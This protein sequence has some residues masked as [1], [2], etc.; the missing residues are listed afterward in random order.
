MGVQA[1]GGG[2]TVLYPAKL[3]Q[4]FMLCRGPT[5]AS[6]LFC[7][8]NSSSFPEWGFQYKPQIAPLTLG[9]PESD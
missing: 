2:V 8:K 4:E 5:L 7:Q 6:N 9:N 3:S 1:R